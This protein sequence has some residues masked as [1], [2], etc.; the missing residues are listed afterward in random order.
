MRKSLICFVLVLG[1]AVSPALA[2]PMV[3]KMALVTIETSTTV[4]A[5]PAQVW[6]TLTDVAKAKIWCPYW[7]GEPGTGSLAAVGK[8]LA[9][10][11]EYG[12]PG[13]SVVVFSDSGKQLRIAHVPDDGSYLCQTTFRLAADGSGTKLT[14]VEQYSDQMD[15]PLDKDTAA[16]AKQ[17]ED[18]YVTALKKMAET[19]NK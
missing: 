2:E 11:D 12:N 4:A 17:A 15:V 1:G 6:A 14:V 5:P 16:S 8:S 7:A 3:T 9:Y 18:A 19:G 13:R 10:K